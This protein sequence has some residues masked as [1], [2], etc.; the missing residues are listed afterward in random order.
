MSSIYNLLTHPF[1]VM[2]EPSY[3]DTSVL[4]VFHFVHAYV[5]YLKKCSLFNLG[6]ELLNYL[7]VIQ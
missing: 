3:Y 5:K 7:Y 6:I 2:I 1:I 4:S